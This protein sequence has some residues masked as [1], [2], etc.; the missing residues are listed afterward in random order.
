MTSRAFFVCR[1]FSSATLAGAGLAALVS[2]GGAGCDRAHLTASH[3]RAYQQAFAVQTVNPGRVAPA[4]A[5]HGLDSQEA[6]IIAS[7]YRRG[8]A[9]KEQSAGTERPQ[10]LLYSPK[11][12]LRDAS[13]PPP[14]VPGER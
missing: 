13:M 7:S 2:L 10:V 1:L 14:S 11:A 8:L 6:A 9:P 4:N 5:V 3:G 12:G